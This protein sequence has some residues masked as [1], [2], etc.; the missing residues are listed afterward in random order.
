MKT[1]PG[2]THD[3]AA[4]ASK[5]EAELRQLQHAERKATEVKELLTTAG[6]FSW[7]IVEAEKLQLHIHSTVKRAEGKL[8]ELKR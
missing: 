4:Q 2:I 5:L 3:Y 7:L 6:C 1:E 8:K